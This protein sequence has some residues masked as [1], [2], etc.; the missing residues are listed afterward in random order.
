MNKN[1]LFSILILSVVLIAS[2][3]STPE[4]AE[5]PTETAP[6][7]EVVEEV[8]DE[9]AGPAETPEPEAV[10]AVGEEELALARQ[11]LQRAEEVDASR[12]APDLMGEA[13]DA[14]NRASDLAE[15][16]P[17]E[18]RK[19]LAAVV[20]K[21]DLAF[22]AGKEGLIA[23][24]LQ[25]MAALEKGLLDIEADKFSPEAYAEV[26]AQFADTRARIEEEDLGEAKKSFA[27]TAV[28]ARNLHR[29]L[30][31]NI[32]WI[33]ILE[34]DTNDYLADA[35]KEEAYLWADE[36]F[37]QA[38][39]LLSQGMADFRRYDLGGSEAV[40]KKAKFQARNAVYLARTR[41]KQSETDQLLMQIQSQLE[42]A[43]MLKVQT[44]EGDIL[45]SD[46]WSGREYLEEN[47]LQKVEADSYEGDGSS[48]LR[49][50]LAKPLNEEVEIVEE[51]EEEV[52]SE[53]QGVA[54]LL[55]QAK[56]LWQ[57]GVKARN[58]GDYA[59]SKE[60]FVQAEAYIKAYQANAVGQTY[61][62]R[63][64]PKDRDCLWKIAGFESTYGDPFL[65]PKIWKRNQ[66]QIPNPDLIYPGQVLI[67]PPLEQQEAR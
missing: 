53:D 14:M 45:D 39:D 33:K 37:L 7:E 63:Y 65:W 27:L 36:E 1:I 16:D 57:E 66:K 28:K 59:R 48:L 58:D 38:S 31:V 61:T 62:V 17:E 30:S 47:P 49:Y 24:A 29:Q 19:L 21:G 23:E 50:D 8:I 35:E 32:R 41:K 18:A 54:G 22:E 42:E 25:S 44:E 51:E 4:P 15:S 5:E 13:Y 2:C 64:D 55:D 6:P 60:L 3:K 34:R 46:P 12:F 40:L 11:A 52:L 26:Q 43:S 67:I 20:E 10:K 9:G 56:A